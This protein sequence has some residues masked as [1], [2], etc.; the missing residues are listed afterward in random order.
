MTNKQSFDSGRISDSE[1]RWLVNVDQRVVL[2]LLLRVLN[3]CFK[4]RKAEG[5]SGYLMI[6]LLI[7]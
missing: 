5:E 7:R 3:P 2:E 6:N 4:M 1:I